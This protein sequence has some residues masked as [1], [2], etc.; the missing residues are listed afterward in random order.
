[1]PERASRAERAPQQLPRR[2][3]D[4]CIEY[5]RP[6]LL[7]CLLLSSFWISYQILSV[8]PGKGVTVSRKSF[9]QLGL[10]LKQSKRSLFKGRKKMGTIQS[11]ENTNHERR[12]VTARRASAA[13]FA[14]A[15]STAA[16][17]TPARALVPAAPPWAHSAEFSQ[18]IVKVV[19]SYQAT[20]D[21]RQARQ[22]AATANPR[23]SVNSPNVTPPTPCNTFTTHASCEQELGCKWQK[24]TPPVPPLGGPGYCY[25]TLPG[26]AKSGLHKPQ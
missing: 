20:K 21:R 19:E 6:T 16:S 26:V 8:G 7:T 1:M 10:D 11:Q 15:I 9:V 14:L 12:S 25:A 5:Q 3:I 18:L 23:W 4:N 13:L 24:G 17:F 22:R 2:V